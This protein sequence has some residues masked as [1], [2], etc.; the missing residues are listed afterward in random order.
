MNARKIIEARGIDFDERSKKEAEK[1]KQAEK[2]PLPQVNPFSKKSTE[3][4]GSDSDSDGSQ[5]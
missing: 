5:A 2:P 4:I 1:Q 3:A